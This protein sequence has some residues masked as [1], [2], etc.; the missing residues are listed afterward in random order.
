MSAWYPW[1]RAPQSTVIMSPAANGRADGTWCGMA[2][3]GPL[4]TM[5]SKASA[6]RAQVGHGPLQGDGQLAL[7]HARPDQRHD[8]ARTRAR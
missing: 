4:A 7:G 6:V 5:V 1:Y 3:F 8:L 2:P